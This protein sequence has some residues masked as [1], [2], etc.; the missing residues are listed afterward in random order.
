MSAPC[1][2]VTMQTFSS[3][4]RSVWVQF[5]RAAR[6]PT[7]SQ[8]CLFWVIILFYFTHLVQWPLAVS[9]TVQKCEEKHSRACFSSRIL[10]Y[11]LETAGEVVHCQ[12]HIYPCNIP[13][14]PGKKTETIPQSLCTS[15][16]LRRLHTKQNVC[17]RLR[18]H[19]HYI[20]INFAGRLK[21][22]HVYL[23][24]L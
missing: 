17:I 12:K 21:L 3:T 19:F 11:F 5:H 23:C 6:S 24:L 22:A 20:Q 16:C 9:L 14:Q 13:E 2:C 1:H 15:V 10:L 7:D 8:F 4:H 18:C